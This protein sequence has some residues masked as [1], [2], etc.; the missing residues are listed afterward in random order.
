MM[1]FRTR[2]FG[3]VRGRA[4]A[5]RWGETPVEFAAAAHRAPRARLAAGVLALLAAAVVGEAKGG[6]DPLTELK[7]L[8]NAFQEVVR[9]VGPSVVGVRVRRR[10]VD[11]TG[12]SEEQRARL[13]EQ[14]VIVNGSGTIIHSDGLILTN[15]HVVHDAFSIEITFHDGQSEVGKI[16]ASDARSDLAIVRVP[17]TGLTAARFC[18]FSRVERGQWTVALGNPFGLGGDGQSSVSVGVISNLHRRLPGLGE[19]DDRLYDDMIQTTADINPGN[20]GGPLLNLDGELVGVVTAMH[21]RSGGDEGVGFALPLDHLRRR[22]IERLCAGRPIEYGYVGLTVRSAEAGVAVDDVEPTGPAARAGVRPGDLIVRFDEMPVRDSTELSRLVG[23]TP[24]GSRV[25]LE[26]MR[27]GESLRTELVVA[28]RTPAR[29][30]ALRGSA[31]LWRGAR[32]AERT[33]KSSGSEGGGLDLTVIGVLADTPAER[34]GLTRGDVVTHVDG[35]PV[36]DLITM[37]SRLLAAR[38]A[39]VLRI[40]RRGDVVI[41]P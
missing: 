27:D 25:P 19:S 18:D 1:R 23:R 40:A 26:L 14:L 38:G 8:E 4:S 15:E 21:T 11:D 36:A 41:Q 20:S 17:R 39:I 2:A 28:R 13:F 9:E 24:A 35:D 12:G 30:A 7:R 34:A 16:V 10:C 37:R 32:L 33:R 6:T 3:S 5:A 29:A 31:I 22:M